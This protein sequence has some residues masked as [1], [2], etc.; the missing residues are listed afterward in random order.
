MVICFFCSFFSVTFNVF[1]FLQ[2]FQS[3]STLPLINSLKVSDFQ[4]FAPFSSSFPLSPPLA[5]WPTL[6]ETFGWSFSS[7][8]SRHQPLRFHQ[9]ASENIFA[10]IFFSLTKLPS[11]VEEEYHIMRFT[12]ISIFYEKTKFMKQPRFSPRK[13]MYQVTSPP[14]QKH[15]RKR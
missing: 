1:F 13:K 8:S 10:S 6:S 5:C 14:P 15:Q 2:M 3:A 9:F 12:T 7:E 11:S 4:V